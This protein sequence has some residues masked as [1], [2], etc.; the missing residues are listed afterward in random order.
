MGGWASG[1]REGPPVMAMSP[2][3]HMLVDGAVA[4]VW[5]QAGTSAGEGGRERGAV[6]GRGQGSRGLPVREGSTEV[7][8]GWRKRGGGGGGA[9]KAEGGM[10]GRTAAD[11]KPA[12][13]ARG[14]VGGGAKRQALQTGKPGAWHGTANRQSKPK[15]SKGARARGARGPRRS[16]RE[17]SPRGRHFIDDRLEGWQVQ[18]LFEEGHA[19][20]AGGGERIERRGER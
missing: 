2:E 3:G 11:E 16:H 10:G 14:R 7:N 13:G 12:G 1:R 18:H 20:A 15:E 19:P 8:A 17:A 5:V 4:L 9:S 6:M